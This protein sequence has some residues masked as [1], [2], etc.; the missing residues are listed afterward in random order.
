MKVVCVY[1][2]GGVIGVLQIIC[3]SVD[4]MQMCLQ[5]QCAAGVDA[6]KLVCDL[7]CLALQAGSL[8]CVI[9]LDKQRHACQESHLLSLVLI[10]KCA[11]LR[12]RE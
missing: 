10:C 3:R 2:F 9:Q 11:N 12:I 7:V 6:S 4:P 1:V 5:G 8:V